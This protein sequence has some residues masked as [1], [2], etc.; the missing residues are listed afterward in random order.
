LIARRTV[1]NKT[2]ALVVGGETSGMGTVRCLAYE[3]VPVAIADWRWHPALFSLHVKRKQKLP[4]PVT[5]QS[6]F[7][8]VL[9][10]FGRTFSKKPVLFP[11]T[12]EAVCLIAECRNMLENEFHVPLS[13]FDVVETILNKEKLYRFLEKSGYSAPRTIYNPIS[14]KDTQRIGFPCLIKPAY[15]H[16]FRRLFRTK[17]MTARNDKELRNALALVSS[18]DISVCIQEIIPSSSSSIVSALGY[19]DKNSRPLVLITT[20][21]VREWPLGF[22]TTCRVRMERLPH[23]ALLA[24]QIVRDLGYHGIADLDFIE[25]RRDGSLKLIDF[26]PR[27]CV[28]I[29]L[30][31]KS[32]SNIPF[33]AYMDS[34]R[35][36]LSIRSRS[37]TLEW[38][39]LGEDL[40]SCLFHW[41][42]GTFSL[43]SL[44]RH[45]TAPAIHSTLSASDPLPAAQKTLLSLRQ[46]LEYAADRGSAMRNVPN[47]LPRESQLPDSKRFWNETATRFG[48]DTLAVVMSPTAPKIVNKIRDFFQRRA[49]TPVLA[50]LSGKVVL[51]IGCGNGRWL[52]RG[53]R[54]GLEM[55]G[56]DLSVKMLHLAR[57]QFPNRQF[58]LVNAEGSHIPLRNGVVDCVLSVTALQHVIAQDRLVKTISEFRRSLR[59]D[60]SVI[61]LE[62]AIN[63]HGREHTTQDYATVA[64]S[65]K[66]WRS[67]FRDQRLLLVEQ[68]PVYSSL[69]TKPLDIVRSS[70][71][72]TW[73]FYSCQLRDQI[74]T[75]Q[76][77][78]KILW[79]IASVVLSVL[80]FPLDLV[81]TERLARLSVHRIMIFRVNRSKQIS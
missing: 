40:V 16:E 13:G 74:S 14:E 61:L 28:E 26:N 41:W 20:R 4:D 36:S 65:L 7:I 24:C 11:C 34:L 30:S 27:C 25:D 38:A 48:G 6:K 45:A 80:S 46:L 12:D 49:L 42:H 22:G 75:V 17:V 58:E 54:T 73:R 44:F 77:L 29:Y 19:F 79:D 18:C 21:R 1:E 32:R 33:V 59:P 50:S 71:A 76:R 39:N 31:A 2:Y 60:G 63:E 57:N 10:A 52:S 70:V 8:E 35:I 69:G 72:K 53:S 68:K 9:S 78:L 51:E 5:D 47:E 55:I 62:T 56:L 81:L 66:S 64:R 15:S 23:V 67:M 37:E 3:D 43:S